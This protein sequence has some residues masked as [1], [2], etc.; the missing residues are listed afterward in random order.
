ME[1]LPNHIEKTIIIGIQTCKKMSFKAFEVNDIQEKTTY[2]VS[3]DGDDV[4]IK[5]INHPTS[6][7]RFMSD[8]KKR[9]KIDPPNGVILNMLSQPN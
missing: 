2:S 8:R 5:I 9:G 7:D 1:N 6:F 4:E 3:F